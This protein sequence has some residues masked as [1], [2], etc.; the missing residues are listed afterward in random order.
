MRG[1][2]IGGGGGDGSNVSNG[3]GRASTINNGV[4]MTHFDEL[5]T[6]VIN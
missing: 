4:L 3:D 5:F 1:E 6:L 2:V